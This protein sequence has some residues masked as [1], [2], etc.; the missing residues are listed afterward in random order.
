MRQSGS[1]RAVKESIRYTAADSKDW[2]LAR[3]DTKGVPS[4]RAIAKKILLKRGRITGNAAS[5]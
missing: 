2:N 3:S 5:S 4:M 1:Q